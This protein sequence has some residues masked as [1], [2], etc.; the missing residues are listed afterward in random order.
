MAWPQRRPLLFDRGLP[1]FQRTDGH[2]Y[3]LDDLL[4][5]WV[6][7]QQLK[8]LI[9][10][11]PA[12]KRDNNPIRVLELGCGIGTVS[13]MM[14]WWCLANDVDNVA[15]TSVEAQKISFDL[16]QRSL[17]FNGVAPYIHLIHAD[18]RTATL[19]GTFDMVVGTPPYFPTTDGWVSDHVQRGPCR[20]ELRGGIEAYAA[21]AARYVADGGM[22]VV[23]NAVLNHARSVGAIGAE[24]FNL[25][26]IQQV[27]PKAERQ[28][29]F[30]VYAAHQ[31]ATN[32]KTS[33]GHR[34]ARVDAGPQPGNLERLI[35]R[36]TVRNAQGQR[37]PEFRTIR[38]QMGFPH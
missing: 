6:A 12:H 11:P 17:A 30:E 5:A 36:L 35:K 14:T 15:F 28:P 22:F 33:R 21:A 24:G 8:K 34:P 31:S 9:A 16:A 27:I 2:R 1:L 3:S 7:I 29:L 20:F 13:L 23:C 38:Q 26:A 18:F 4:T 10:K 37:T 32:A 25:D 19:P